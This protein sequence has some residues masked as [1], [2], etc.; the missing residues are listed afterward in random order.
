M[1]NFEQFLKAKEIIP[2]GVNSP[3]RSFY[4]VGGTPFFTVKAKD[5]WLYDIEGNSYIDFICSWGAN[6][7]GH[8]NE[9]ISNKVK[10]AVDQGLSYGTPTV[11]EVELAREIN[12]LVPSMEKVR[13]V[14]SG[15]EGTM[16]AIRLARGYSG[17]S[18]IVKFIGCY[19]GHCDS[20]LVSAGSGCA[21]FSVPNSKGVLPEFAHYTLLV[22][23]NDSNQLKAI[24]QQY[25]HEIAAIIL[26][27][28][29]GNM[30]FVKPNTEFLSTIKLL[31]DSYKSLLIVDEVMTG[32]RV[33][34]GGAQSVFDISPDITVLGKIV[35]GG[36]PLAAFGGKAEIMDCLAPVGGVYQA[37]TLSGNPISVA[38]GLA[39]LKMIQTESFQETINYI[40]QE[41]TNII[42]T[43]AKRHNLPII[44]D[45]QGGMFGLF[46][47]N[48]LPIN[49]E[50]VSQIN[51]ELYNKFF[52]IALR[53]GVFFPP[54]MFE[55]CFVNIKHV[56]ILSGFEQVMDEIFKVL[57]QSV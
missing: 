22:A 5:C 15:T 30:N 13:L 40:V 19:H 16:S 28:I 26:E 31:C 48:N 11:G 39:N 9:T 24:F 37:G 53:N 33:A 51:K 36:M 10:V 52:A 47:A 55:A 41:I 50:Q 2:G 35:G 43:S 4:A 8:A 57:I 46:F 38:A 49:F 32:F 27:P 44:C 34:L 20:L 23:Y 25:G 45:S 54:S 29:A 18:Y 14:N 6:I 7:V 17:R 12:K 21:T 3:V 42:T 1:N 56:N